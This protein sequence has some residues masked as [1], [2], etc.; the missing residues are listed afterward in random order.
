VAAAQAPVGITAV[1]ESERAAEEELT[2]PTPG[3]D[4]HELVVEAGDESVRIPVGTVTGY[5]EGP[6]LLVVAGVHGSE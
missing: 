4:M 6:T 1:G 2:M 3:T 5:A